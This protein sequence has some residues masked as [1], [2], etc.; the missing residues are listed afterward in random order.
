[1]T[2]IQEKDVAVIGRKKINVSGG[3]EE[4]AESVFGYRRRVSRDLRGPP[5]GTLEADA[6]HSN[7]QVPE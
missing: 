2:K 1:L 3:R 6:G 4:A 5:A 7:D